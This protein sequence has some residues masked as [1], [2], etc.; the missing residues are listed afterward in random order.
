[1]IALLGQPERLHNPRYHHGGLQPA[2]C[3]D[4]ERPCLAL[5]DDATAR[6]LL[7]F[8]PDDGR[9]Q[10]APPETCGSEPAPSLPDFVVPTRMGQAFPVWLG[11]RERREVDGK[12]GRLCRVR[13]APEDADAWTD[14]VRHRCSNRGGSEDLT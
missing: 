6:T 1:M 4:D 2:I 10:A 7:V 9:G 11:G 13:H 5:V 14:L 3:V 12:S 8:M